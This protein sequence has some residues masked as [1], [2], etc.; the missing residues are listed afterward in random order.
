MPACHFTLGTG[1]A[2]TTRPC[3]L[4]YQR[5]YFFYQSNHLPRDLPYFPL[6][7]IAAAQREEVQQFARIHRDYHVRGD[8]IG[9]HQARILRRYLVAPIRIPLFNLHHLAMEALP[10]FLSQ[11][12]WH[13]ILHITEFD[14]TLAL[15]RKTGYPVPRDLRQQCTRDAAYGKGETRMLKHAEMSTC[16]YFFYEFVVGRTRSVACSGRVSHDPL[17]FGRKSNESYCW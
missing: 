3:V 13:D 17:R 7:A 11:I 12:G 5:G 8:C 4:K 2:Y 14:I 16:H 6:R 10:L 1:A 15:H 9:Q